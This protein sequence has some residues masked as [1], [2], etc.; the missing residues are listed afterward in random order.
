M[1]VTWIPQRDLTI[2]RG[3]EGKQRLDE[4]AQGVGT[5]ADWH[6]S[7]SGASAEEKIMERVDEVKFAMEYAETQGVPYDRVFPPRAGSTYT[8]EEPETPEKEEPEDPETPDK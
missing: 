3:R 1:D 8:G 2:D 6:K 4:I 7:M 5:F